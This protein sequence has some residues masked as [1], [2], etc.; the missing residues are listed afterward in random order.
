MPGAVDI[1][2]SHNTLNRGLVYQ[3]STP[4]TLQKADDSLEIIGYFTAI[5]V[6]IFPYRS[7]TYGTWILYSKFSTN[8]LPIEV[9]ASVFLGLWKYLPCIVLSMTSKWFGCEEYLFF[10]IVCEPLSVYCDKC[11]WLFSVDAWHRYRARLH[12]IVCWFM[13]VVNYCIRNGICNSTN[14]YNFLVTWAMI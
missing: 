3:W 13:S 7:R 12:Y 8:H 10:N 2:L 5:P 11:L 4:H 6:L 14:Q 1:N 9:R